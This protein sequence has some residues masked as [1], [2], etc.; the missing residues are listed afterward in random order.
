MF[1]FVSDE[2]ITQYGVILDKLSSD[3]PD[4]MLGAI[5][6]YV[7]NGASDDNMR[8]FS[9]EF[10]ALSLR[11]VDAK[12]ELDKLNAHHRKIIMKYIITQK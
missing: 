9:F 6:D 10:W 1:E 4:K 8:A 12:I 11:N 2:Y 5:V 3:Q 7:L